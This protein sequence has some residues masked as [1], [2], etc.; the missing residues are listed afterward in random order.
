MFV[1]LTAVFLSLAT[2]LR[3]LFQNS[4]PSYLIHDRVFCH[5]ADLSACAPPNVGRTLNV[6]HIFTT[7]LS[8]F[9]LQS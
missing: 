1:V 4:L 9:P 2:A 7:G 6:F 8:I 5:A 3:S